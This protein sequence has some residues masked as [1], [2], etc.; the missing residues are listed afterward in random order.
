MGDELTAEGIGKKASEMGLSLGEHT[1]NRIKTVCANYE[2][3]SMELKEI[4]LDMAYSLGYASDLEDVEIEAIIGSCGLDF[5][6]IVKKIRELLF[7][8]SLNKIRSKKTIEQTRP[9]GI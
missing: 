9:R 4:L 1:I 5:P 7:D 2:C 6:C 8:E 3:V